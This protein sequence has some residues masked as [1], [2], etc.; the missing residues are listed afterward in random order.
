MNMDAHFGF[1]LAAYIAG[2]VI[3]AVMIVLT[4]FDYASL[5][6]KLARLSARAGAEPD[7]D[8]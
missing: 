4:V 7:H 6:K 3:L 5:K 8:G 1:I 2:A